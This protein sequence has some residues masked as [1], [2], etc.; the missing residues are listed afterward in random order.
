MSKVLK[1]LFLS[2][3]ATVCLPQQVQAKRFTIDT[4]GK[5]G[6]FPRFCL[7]VYKWGDR[8]FNTVDTAY[9]RGT[10]YKFNVKLNADSWIDYYHFGLQDGSYCTMYSQPSTTLGPYITYLAVSLGYSITTSKLLG[11]ADL[12]RKRFDFSFNCALIS[13]NFYY[14]DNTTGSTISHFGPRGSDYDCKQ[15]FTGINN[16][17]YGARLMYMLNNKKYSYGAAFSYS[18]RQIKSAGSFLFGIN[19]QLQTASFDFDQLPVEMQQRL[20]VTWAS[21]EYKLKSNNYSAIIGYGYNW[22][23]HRDWL[24]G[25]AV[26][27]TIGWRYGYQANED[28]KK[29]GLSM[30]ARARLALV[31]NR[32]SWFV[33]MTGDYDLNSYFSR[34]HTLVTSILSMNV[35]VGVRFNLF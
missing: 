11:Q 13:A 5:Y 3:I 16:K 33:G 1:I 12:R 28:L 35:Q 10:G 17:V 23:M 15:N 31:F 7:K 30:S 2:L 21:H 9:V 34:S 32:R 20:P 24:L 29:Y 8:F 6:K 22:V 14:Y 26:L 18:K 25:V 4:L 27:P 19:L